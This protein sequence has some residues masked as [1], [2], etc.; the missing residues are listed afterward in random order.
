MGWTDVVCNWKSGARNC[1]KNQ[2]AKEDH[3]ENKMVR[4]E[5]KAI[6]N[7]ALIAHDAKKG[8]LIRWCQDNYA[9]LRRH[10]LF[11]TGTT[12]AMIRENTGLNVHGFNSGPL[13]GDLQ[14][15]AKIVEGAIDFVVFF[16]DPLTAAPHD[17]DVKALLRI[18]QL[19]D[20]PM[21]NNKSSADFMITSSYIDT[22]YYHEVIDYAYNI[23]ARVELLNPDKDKDE[24]SKTK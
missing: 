7:I 3:M 8:E 20:I 14:I 9:V 11:G 10:N 6:K 5:I 1:I 15:G 21:A 18:A 4:L 24:T 2:I 22:S 16:A 13:G 12:S 19:Y 17:P 23:K